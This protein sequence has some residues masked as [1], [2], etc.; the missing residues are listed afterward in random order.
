MLWLDD[1]LIEGSVAPFDL[2]DRG[3]TLGDGL[4]DTAL[5]IGGRIAF[6]ERHRERLVAGAR[7]L[8]FTVEPVRIAR[9][10][11]A[12]ADQ[13]PRLSV[14][15]TVT[16]GTG[17]RGIR[18][19]QDPRITVFAMATPVVATASF[20]PLRLYPVCIRRNET[21]PA[22]RLKTLGYLDA[23]LGSAEAVREGFDEPLF[24]NTRG[25]VACAGSGN[26]FVLRGR[27]LAT[28]PLS[29]G[30]LDGIVREE[31]LTL[32]GGNGIAASERSLSPDDLDGAE[33][34]FLTNSLRL[35][36]PVTAI[37]SRAME[38]PDHPVVRMLQAALRRRV[39]EDC[40]IAPDDVA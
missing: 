27:E 38:S 16:R 20:A 10:M 28:P 1:R 26:L 15:T 40:G 3:L 2:T 25:A 11:R 37:G 30:V 12:L 24:L 29:D 5:A 17:P 18:P 34:V 6:E 39:A 4:F 35:L 23:V 31:I 13:G 36:S 22:A 21:S 32:A 14:R 33:A 8:G 19:P 9:A 7:T